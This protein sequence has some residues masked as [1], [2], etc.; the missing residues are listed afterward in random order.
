MGLPPAVAIF[1]VLHWQLSVFFQSF[2]LHRYAAHRMFR[3]SPFWERAFHLATY[4]A[5]GSSYLR[6]SAYALLHRLHHAHADA[7][8]DPHS[9][10]I[11]GSPLAL[12]AAMKRNYE[13]ISRRGVVPDTRLAGNAPV[14]PALD[15]WGTSYTSS[16][17]WMLFYSGYYL[18][19]ASSAWQYLLLPLHFAMGPL[20]G[21]IV[22]WFGHWRGYRNFDTHDR[23]CN[24]L[25]IELVTCG[26]L[27]QNNHH[28]HPTSPNFARRWFELDPAYPLILLFDRLGVIQL[29]RGQPS[30]GG[31][32]ELVAPGE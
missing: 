9:P 16:A 17:L 26:E 19:F 27:F 12:M 7:E 8:G 18:I 24:T 11:H 21:T 1:F 2:F 13:D 29:E 10:T 30:E 5:Q 6:P 23:S 3:M 25:W 22:N 32:A 14:W 4:L 31:L 15:E 20:H 28:R